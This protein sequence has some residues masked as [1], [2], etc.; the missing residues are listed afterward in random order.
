MMAQLAR[1]ASPARPYSTRDYQPEFPD[2]SSVSRIVRSP[3]PL[4]NEFA[5]RENPIRPTEISQ[6][7]IDALAGEMK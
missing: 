6:L 2:W 7:L 1:P 5:T 4:H 3:S